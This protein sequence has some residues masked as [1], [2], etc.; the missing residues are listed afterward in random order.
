MI[1]NMV[2]TGE[3]S[4]QL[5][6]VME[7]IAPF[8]KERMEGLIAKVSKMLEPIIIVGM[9]SAVATMMLSIYLPM[10]EMSGNVK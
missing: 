1:I 7:Q 9:G 5:A 6:D 4:G 3:E 2:H 8:Y 10:F